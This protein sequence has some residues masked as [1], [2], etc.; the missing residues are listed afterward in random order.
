MVSAAIDL[1]EPGGSLFVGD[2]RS[3]DQQP[4]FAAAVELAR[5]P[6]AMTAAE[7]ASRVEHRER[8]DEELVVDPGLFHALAARRPDVVDVDVRIKPGG[9]RTR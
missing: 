6:A 2:V 4:L 7:L 5:A 8:G 9:P 3:R 1:L